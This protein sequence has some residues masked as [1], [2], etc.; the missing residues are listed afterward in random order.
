MKIKILRDCTAKMDQPLHPGNGCD[1]SA[2]NDWPCYAGEE[3]EQYQLNKM[4]LSGLK[5]K[6]DYEIT[7]YP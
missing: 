7:E 1:C 3:Y 6:E 4:D 2:M 5:F